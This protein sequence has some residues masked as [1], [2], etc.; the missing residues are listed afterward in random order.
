MSLPNA[1][2]DLLNMDFDRS[3]VK[4]DGYITYSTSGLPAT[5]IEMGLYSFKK[6]NGNEF[7]WYFNTAV[8]V[9]GCGRHIRLSC[10][11]TA[12]HRGVGLR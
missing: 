3:G 9:K 10:K 6:S 12:G 4:R 11:L 5:S 2:V 7:T 8:Y 1:L